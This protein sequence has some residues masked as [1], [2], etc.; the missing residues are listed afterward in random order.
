M[1]VGMI[2]LGRMGGQMAERLLQGGHQVVAFDRNAAAVATAV[3]AGAVGAGSLADL[4][5]RCVEPRVCWVML[6]AGEATDHTIEALAHVLEPG[7]TVVDGGNSR[8][9]DS[10]RRGHRLGDRGINFLDCGTSGGVWGLSEGYCLM[11]GGD[12]AA[13]A[14]VEPVFA[15]LAQAGGYL[16]T[17][18]VGSGHYVKMI[19]NG[20]EYGMLEAYAEGFELMANHE[21]PLDLGAIADLWLHGSV[22]RSWLLEL[23]SNAL[24]EHPRLEGIRG[25]VED[26]GEGRWTV[27][28]AVRLGVPLP[29]LAFSLFERFRSRQED[30]WSDR[31]I[32]ALRQQFGGHS[33]R[34]S[35]VEGDT[36]GGGEGI[37]RRPGDPVGGAAGEAGG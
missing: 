19:H 10:R 36:Q 28:E 26:S 25:Y 16:H 31:F 18:P 32:A 12:A 5:A 21:Y 14:R 3:A 22:V 23:A 9:Q 20:I 7:D 2:G 6:P 17:G 37:G 11:V 15:T 30:A 29:A 24:R 34:R 35:G 27:E 33:V 13:F 4:V 1:Q 8:Y